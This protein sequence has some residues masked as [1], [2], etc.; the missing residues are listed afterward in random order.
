M[1]ESGNP[2]G[3]R[4][5]GTDLPFT[6][7]ATEVRAVLEAF[8]E[9]LETLPDLSLAIAGFRD[10]SLRVPIWHLVEDL[11]LQGYVALYPYF[12]TLRDFPRFKSDCDFWIE[13]EHLG[14]TF[15]AQT[16]LDGVQNCTGVHRRALFFTMVHPGKNEG[17]SRLMR[18]WLDY[19]RSTG[20]RIHLVHYRYDRSAVTSAMRRRAQ[21]EYDL[22]REINVESPLVGLNR[23]GSN[24]DVD[25]WTGPEVVEAVSE[26][27]QTFAY[28]YAVV[29][30]GFS[31]A[32]FE[33]VHAYTRK[34]LLTHDVFADRN[35][36]M[37]QQGFKAS[38]WASVEPQGE[39]T[40]SERSDIVVAIQKDEQRMLAEML[41]KNTDIR[42]IC[43]VLEARTVD[44]R[45][46]TDKLR[47]GFFGSPNG[48]NQSNL[49][50]YIDALLE[51]PG[52]PERVEIV[53]AGG[54]CKD[55]NRHIPQDKLDSVSASLFGE[56][57][58]LD[59][60]FRECDIVVNPERGGTGIKIKSLETMAHGMPLLSTIAGASGLDSHSRFHNAPDVPSLAE[61]TEEIV[62]DDNLLDMVRR[63]T[64]D[65]YESYKSLH[66]GGLAEIFG[67]G[68]DVELAA[69]LITCGTPAT[70]DN[71]IALNEVVNLDEDS[72]DLSLLED[73]ARPIEIAD[74]ANAAADLRAKTR[75][76]K[77]M[78]T[79]Y[80]ERDIAQDRGG[81][82][83]QALARMNTKFDAK[84]LLI[85]MATPRSIRRL[86]K[87][88]RHA[89]E[90]PWQQH[91]FKYPWKFSEWRAMRRLQRRLQSDPKTKQRIL[92]HLH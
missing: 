54:L 19:I 11:G 66:R 6:G 76:L 48:V 42:L 20:C 28:D 5:I 2:S 51:R 22:Y 9:I 33:R 91:F 40:A 55:I 44:P 3:R 4:L 62:R 59:E 70:R 81:A 14:A 31:S 85:S 74:A 87:R 84:L 71:K 29:N 58:L 72:M 50:D 83:A 17:N 35:A 52:V 78:L 25:D 16:L 36:R 49:L 53:L 68:N 64:I 24:I 47:I 12:D 57:S 23:S 46:R 82:P 13:R 63:D 7:D 15:S 32:V 60:F 34:I 75:E 38:G 37:L 89:I 30:Y 21:V 73:F 61:L 92:D 56:V 77:Y 67:R 90:T 69:C 10:R 80:Q 86:A 26:L 18:M 1:R 41:P 8:K 27:T 79:V 45:A 39:V 88:G 43:P 65:A